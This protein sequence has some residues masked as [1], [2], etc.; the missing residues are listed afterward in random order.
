MTQVLNQSDDSPLCS[1]MAMLVK[2][3][4]HNFDFHIIQIYFFLCQ[5][6]LFLGSHK[7]LILHM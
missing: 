2:N 1:R 6:T 4:I 3:R 5:K 7:Y